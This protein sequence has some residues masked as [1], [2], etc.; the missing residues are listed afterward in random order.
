MLWIP[1]VIAICCGVLVVLLCFVSDGCFGCVALGL[2]LWLVALC[3]FDWLTFRLVLWW[4]ELQFSFMVCVLCVV[5]CVFVCGYWY[6]SLFSLLL[7]LFC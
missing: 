5:S 3:C 2:C 6:C 7:R 4:F 1:W